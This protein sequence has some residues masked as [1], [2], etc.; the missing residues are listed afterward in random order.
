MH[1]ERNTRDSRD[2][3]HP[4]NRQLI[5]RGTVCIALGVAC[6]ICALVFTQAFLPLWVVACTFF[7]VGS[8]LSERYRL[9]VRALTPFKLLR[10]VL[11]AFILVLVLG[12][13]LPPL[14]SWFIETGMARR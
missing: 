6:A 13:G 7:M 12:F 11:V 2:P 4:A 8:T 9:R 3:R 10:S 1:D 14:L 5:W